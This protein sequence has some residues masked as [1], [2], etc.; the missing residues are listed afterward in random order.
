MLLQATPDAPARRW[1][2]A[3]VAAQIGGLA[4]TTAV[5]TYYLRDRAPDLPQIAEAVRDADATWVITA[6]VAMFVS[7]N[8]FAYHQRRLLT[9]MGLHLSHPRALA[10][11]YARTAIACVVPAGSAVSAAYAWRLY[12]A[13][14]ADRRTATATVATSGV[15][16][17]VALIT[18]AT[19]GLLLSTLLGPTP[20]RMVHP[21]TLAAGC[22]I[23]L[24]VLTLVARFTPQRLALRHWASALAAAKASWLAE[25]LCLLF[26]T[27]ALGLD[28]GVFTIAA[29][30]LGAQVARQTPLTPGG[31]GLIE[32]ALLTGLIS[33]GADAVPSAAAVLVYRC[34][35]CWST[36]PIG[37]LGWLALRRTTPSS[38]LARGE[39]GRDLRAGG[40]LQLRQDVLDVLIGGSRGDHQALGDMPVAQPLRDEAGDLGLPPGQ[41][42]G[43]RTGGGG[44]ISFGASLVER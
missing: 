36:I 13:N 5:A 37:L 30:F 23:L 12:R 15:L 21:V 27:R 7:T 8:M 35:S 40:E 24:A 38:P 29:I 9:G 41:H 32:A 19:I 42:T 14:G 25:L 28:I 22:A 16:L 33:A 39:P 34:L 1:M 20:I 44:R 31:I 4:A 43:R 2:S 17:T 18:L 11:S 3:R 26:S 6:T 10:L